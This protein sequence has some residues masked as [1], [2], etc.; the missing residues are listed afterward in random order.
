MKNKKELIINIVA[1]LLA[2]SII[3]VIIAD[4]LFSMDSFNLPSIIAAVLSCLGLFIIAVG[5]VLKYFSKYFSLGIAAGYGSLAVNY[6]F[7][8]FIIISGMI[9]IIGSYDWFPIVLFVVYLIRDIIGVIGALSAVLGCLIVALCV[10]VI[11]FIKKEA[12]QR[13]M[14]YA[15]ILPVILL[16]PP[17]LYE[18]FSVV[19]YIMNIMVG[20]RGLAINML[21]SPILGVISALGQFLLTLLVMFSIKASIPSQKENIQNN[22]Q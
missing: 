2:L 10:I 7:F 13:K 19:N 8:L 22:I 20:Y 5:M 1:A 9:R 17:V 3:P 21:L 11:T 6:I 4:N 14:T 15:F 16:I 18:A 12:T